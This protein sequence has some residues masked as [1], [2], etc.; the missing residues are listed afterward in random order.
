MDLGNQRVTTPRGTT[1]RFEIDPF[2]KDC[3]YRGLDTIG[4]TLEHEAA[5][6][7]YERRR[8]QEAPW[9]FTDIK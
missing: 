4:L 2:R 8:K 9:L 5:I 3:L 7:D 6:S 1:Y